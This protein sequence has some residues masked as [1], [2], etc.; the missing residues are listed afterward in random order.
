MELQSY[1]TGKTAYYRYT[2]CSWLQI[3][4][5]LEIVLTKMVDKFLSKHMLTYLFTYLLTPWSRILLEKQ[6]GFQ[7]VK[8]FPTFYGTRKF[9]TAF[10]SA[11]HQSVS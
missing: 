5:R 8:K 3:P 4:L 2:L 7:L 1:A 11:R 10:T 9:I 6:T